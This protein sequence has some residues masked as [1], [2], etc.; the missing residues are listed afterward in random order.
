MSEEHGWLYAIVIHAIMLQRMQSI[1]Y[2]VVRFIKVFI[3]IDRERPL[4][5]ACR[6]VA[7][8]L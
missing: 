7:S 4:F 1:A 8:N 5:S 6:R 2:E 3:E